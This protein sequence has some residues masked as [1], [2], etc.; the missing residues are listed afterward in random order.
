MFF[1]AGAS[2]QPGEFKPGD[3]ILVHG[4]AFYSR[5]IQ[6]GEWLRY[7]RSDR[8]ACHFTHAA[9]IETAD[10][11]LIE[12]LAN[13]VVRSH[14]SKYQEKDYKIYSISGVAPA[15][16]DRDRVLAYSRS[17][18]GDKYDW[19]DILS[20]SLTLVTGTKLC[21]ETEDH[22]LC[23][24]L[25]ARSLDR[26]NAIFPRNSGHMMPADLA[27]FFDEKVSA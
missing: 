8:N 15:Q 19:I 6:F 22:D 26:S 13:G 17:C 7:R 11:G 2:A 12:A 18:V 24:V 20:V 25:V 9:M 14:I 4:D 16:G 1:P 10:G 3:F 23:S 21:I 5:L 27:E